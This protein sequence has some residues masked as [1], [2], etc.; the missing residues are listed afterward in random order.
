MNVDKQ[1]AVAV[2]TTLG[3]NALGPNFCQQHRG[4]NSASDENRYMKVIDI[5]EIVTKLAPLIFG[6]IV[7]SVALLAYFRKGRLKLGSFTLDLSPNRIDAEIES[8][9]RRT[10][11]SAEA[12]P[13]DRQF[14]LLRE[15]HAQGL[16]QS[17]ISFWFSLVFASLGFA[18]IIAAVMT[19]DRGTAIT[20]QGRTWVTVAA[21][22]IID[23]VA[24]L[25]FVQSNKARELMV[26]FFD[27]LRN[28]RKLEEALKIAA[29]L[30]DPLLNSRLGVI[31]A[32][33]LADTQPS[34][35]LVSKLFSF[36]S[37]P[38]QGMTNMTAA[39]FADSR[40]T[41]VGRKAGTTGL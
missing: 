1:R 28:D 25:F 21:G 10:S 26:E 8:I 32:L 34:D 11:P 40:Q 37:N 15:Y 12:V 14:V 9:R 16:A 5:A 6:L 39:D 7:M 19:I 36:I 17:K 2:K 3:L 33:N 35:D 31:L 24:A 30:P 23:A 13:A 29:T 41:D 27:R 22:T 20:E 38:N 18:V 4:F